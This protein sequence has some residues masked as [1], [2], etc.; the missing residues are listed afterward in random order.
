MKVEVF[1]KEVLEHQSQDQTCNS[2]LYDK[3]SSI[4]E[5][6]SQENNDSERAEKKKR[7]NKFIDSMNEYNRENATS[8]LNK[9]QTNKNKS[10]IP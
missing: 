2:V 5:D 3:I 4:L 8:K 7:S 1:D 10:A 6:K 9:H